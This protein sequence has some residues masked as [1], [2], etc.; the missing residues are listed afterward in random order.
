MTNDLAVDFLLVVSHNLALNRLAKL[1]INGSENIMPI[2]LAD[3]MARAFGG[4]L[5]NELGSLMKSCSVSTYHVAFLFCTVTK[6]E[7][8]FGVQ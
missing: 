6:D 2:R 1:G 8:L 7:N 3:E 5:I 4:C